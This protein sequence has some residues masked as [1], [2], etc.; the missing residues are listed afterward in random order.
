MSVLVIGAGA[1]GLVA[2]HDLQEAG[3]KVK[4]LEESGLVGGRMY[5]RPGLFE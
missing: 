3:I 1:A 4:V 2:A 5:S